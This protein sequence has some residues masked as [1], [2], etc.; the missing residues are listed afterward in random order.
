MGYAYFS[1]FPFPNNPGGPY[2]KN[3]YTEQLP[4]DADVFLC[5]QVMKNFSM[6]TMSE[7]LLAPHLYALDSKAPAMVDMLMAGLRTCPPRLTPVA[8]TPA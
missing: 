4:A 5:Q 6:G 3:T 7:W 8:D 1:L 2:L